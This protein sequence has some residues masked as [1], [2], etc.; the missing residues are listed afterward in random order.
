MFYGWYIAGG[1]GAMNLLVFGIASLG[2]GV[3]IDP[4]REELGWSLA[5]ISLGFSLRSF[6]AGPAGADQRGAG[7]SA[8]PAQDVP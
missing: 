1:G 2:M 7:R 5:A 8:R 3:L 6:E 4:M